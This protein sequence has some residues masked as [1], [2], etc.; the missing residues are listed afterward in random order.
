MM[1]QPNLIMIVEPVLIIPALAGI[2][3]PLPKP[4]SYQ[5][6]IRLTWR[7]ICPLKVVYQMGVRC[8]EAV[9]DIE[10]LLHLGIQNVPCHTDVVG[11]LCGP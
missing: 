1:A 2:P 10:H 8:Y 7:F 9:P 4:L 6:Q 3:N 11:I 5:C